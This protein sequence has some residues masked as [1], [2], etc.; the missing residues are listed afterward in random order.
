MKKL[1]NLIDLFLA[2]VCAGK[3][4]ETEKTYRTKLRQLQRFAGNRSVTR[5][6]IKGFMQDL[7]TR[8]RH[9]HG[10]RVIEGG[11]SVYTIKTVLQ[12]TRHFC[13][14]LYENKYIPED[15]APL[16]VLPSPPPPAPKAISD[17]TVNALIRSAFEN[18]SEEWERARNVAIM[19]Y[20]R[21]TGGRVGGMCYAKLGSIDLRDGSV[22][23]VEKGR[24][25][26]LYINPPT[27]QAI[28]SWIDQRSSLKPITDHLFI[29]NRTK[30]GMTRQGVARMLNR[31]AERAG[32]QERRN[33]HA[34]RHAFARDFLKSGGEL[35]QLAGL[36]NHSS[37]WVTNNYY[38]RWNDK[39]LQ[40]AHALSSP[41]NLITEVSA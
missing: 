1:H 24:N 20:L 9:K 41:V 8:T 19:Y 17:D 35:S 38:A 33:P 25:V 4:N 30:Q 27:V 23:T 5:D 36:M 31:L 7:K 13:R 10:Y 32:I 3:H 16:I 11:L 34:W 2:D 26:K 18:S 39:E 15:I 21:D 37:I 12:T 28:R 22:E 14:W 40:Q 29:S 6:L